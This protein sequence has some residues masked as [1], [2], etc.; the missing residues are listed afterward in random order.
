MLK[1]IFAEN[2]IDFSREPCAG[3]QRA[4][5]CLKCSSCDDSKSFRTHSGEAWRRA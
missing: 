1:S 3:W 4:T 2:Q 5:D